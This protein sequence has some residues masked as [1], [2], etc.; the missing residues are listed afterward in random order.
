MKQYYQTILI[1][2]IKCFEGFKQ[3]NKK[4][5]KAEQPY[6]HQMS[7]KFKTLFSVLSILIIVGENLPSFTLN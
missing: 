1:E 3:N 7:L 5:N 4:K 6:L 2:I